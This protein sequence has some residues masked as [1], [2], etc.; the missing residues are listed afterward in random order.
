M[1]T[2]K[3]L[4]SMQLTSVNSYVEEIWI[5]VSLANQDLIIRCVYIPPNSALLKYSEHVQS[6]QNICDIHPNCEIVV[7]GDFDL[8]NIEFDSGT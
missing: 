5:K 6:L 8:S 4:N 1:T 7:I 2:N 3:K